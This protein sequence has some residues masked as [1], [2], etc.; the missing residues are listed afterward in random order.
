MP[1][2]GRLAGLPC[3]R[4]EGC[5]GGCCPGWSYQRSVSLSCQR[6]KGQRTKEEGRKA[7]LS[8]QTNFGTGL[9]FNAGES[10]ECAFVEE[11]TKTR[12]MRCMQGYLVNATSVSSHASCDVPQKVR[13]RAAAKAMSASLERAIPA[14]RRRQTS[15]P[16]IPY[17]D[18]CLFSSSS[19]SSVGA[20]HEMN[21]AA[22]I[23]DG[24]MHLRAGN[25]R[26]KREEFLRSF[27]VRFL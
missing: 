25:W 14:G 24:S 1:T 19:V 7:L 3:A 22:I 8:T 2:A 6:L 5:C 4:Q 20:Q 26:R 9:N 18:C 10:G 27:W 12:C 21:T 15:F 23:F 13:R 17:Q 16:N 11:L